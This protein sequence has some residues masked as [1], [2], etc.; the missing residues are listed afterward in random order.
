[1]VKSQKFD[2]QEYKQQMF[3]A[4]RETVEEQNGASENAVESGY[5]QESKSSWNSSECSA[6]DDLEEE[7]KNFT[8][9]SKAINCSYMNL[10]RYNLD[11]VHATH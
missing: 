1:M 5:N 10:K 3:S 4:V 9:L 2:E 8:T 7:S 6:I 11:V